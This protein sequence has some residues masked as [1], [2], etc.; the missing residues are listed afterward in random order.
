MYLAQLNIENFRIFGSGDRALNLPL[1]PKLTLILGEN[2]SGKS[3]IIDAIRCVLGSADLDWFRLEGDDFHLKSEKNEDGELTIR[4][5]D[6]LRIEC[7]FKNLNHQE[8]ALFL[9]WLGIDTV[10]DEPQYY[11]RVWLE[12]DRKSSID[13]PGGRITISVKAGP[14]EEGIRFDGPARRNLRVTYL[15][16]LRDAER[17][18][19]ARRGSRLSKILFA[20]LGPDADKSEEGQ[21]LVELLDNAHNAVRSGSAVQVPLNDLRESYFDQLQLRGGASVSPD[22]RIAEANLRSILEQLQLLLADEHGS[23]EKTQHGLGIN[24]LLFMSAEL[25]LLQTLSDFAL[26]LLLIEE[27][28]AHLHPQLQLRLVKFLQEREQDSTQVILTSHSPNIASSISLHQLVMMKDGIAHPMA[29]FFTKLDPTDYGFLER[30]LDVTKANLFFAKGV[31]IVEGDAEQILLPTIAELIERPLDAYGVT[32]V[33]VGHTGLFRYSRIFER[34]DGKDLGVKVACIADLDAPSDFALN[35]AKPPAQTAQDYVLQEKKSDL[36]SR[37]SGNTTHVFV[38]PLWTLE[39]DICLK[40]QFSVHMH[41]AIQ[42]AKSDAANKEGIQDAAE[43]EYDIWINEGLDTQDIAARIYE[44]LYNG[45]ASKAETAQYLAYLL[46]EA[47]RP[48]GEYVEGLPD[49]LVRAI[50]Y[51]TEPLIGTD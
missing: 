50:E 24:N 11:L 29:P 40:P 13:E 30:F 26:P 18:L 44:P 21:K 37:F 2:D 28:E 27:P 22:V 25:L 19:S 47:K 17:E 20:H 49:Y 31:L 41:Q 10:N 7:I 14:D 4:R 32:I 35:Y 6:Q 38:S 48:A 9:E 15:R 39:H 1:D 36:E 34:N 45:R 43:R 12:A 23:N 8:A 33:N 51:V 16:P 46:K 3:A 5:A 42:L